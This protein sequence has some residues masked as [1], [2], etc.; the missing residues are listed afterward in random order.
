MDQM[1]DP[2]NVFDFNSQELDNNF[3]NARHA[4]DNTLRVIFYMK[5]VKNNFKSAKEGRAIFDEK[6]FVKIIV[7]GDR[8]NM[9]DAPV[10]PYHKQRFQAL[11][12]RFE[13]GLEA[14]ET[15]TPLGEMPWMSVGMVEELRAFGVKTVENLA[16]LNDGVVSRIMGATMLKAKAQAF[17]DAAQAD[18][19]NSQLQAALAERDN[20]IDLMKHQMAEMQ[21]TIEG[22]KDT[23]PTPT[24]K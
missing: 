23:S 10:T 7:P 3:L 15:G 11:W 2:V 17:L 18:S 5:A 16:N 20:E 24:K 6:P 9:V 22:L 14:P 21:K 1:N 13:K 8:L 12:E 19:Q 4:R